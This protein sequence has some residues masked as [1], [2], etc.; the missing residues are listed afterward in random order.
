[1]NTIDMMKSD[2]RP[3]HDM[4]AKKKLITTT[5]IDSRSYSTYV[6][7]HIIDSA[8]CDT[9]EIRRVFRETGPKPERQQNYA[10]V[11]HPVRFRKPMKSLSTTCRRTGSQRITR[12]CRMSKLGGGQAGNT[13]PTNNNHCW[14][15]CTY[16]NIA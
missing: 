4:A 2:S 9:D 5:E 11:I 16:A 6:V 10:Y 1:M 13:I 12:I 14:S 7:S 3:G 8:V 15:S